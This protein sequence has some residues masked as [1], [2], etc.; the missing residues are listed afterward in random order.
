MRCRFAALL[1]VVAACGASPERARTAKGLIDDGTFAMLKEVTDDCPTPL[2]ARPEHCP[3]DR[4][5]DNVVERV[6]IVTVE[7]DASGTPVRAVDL[8]DRANEACAMSLRYEG[9]GTCTVRLRL[10]R[11]ISDV[12]PSRLLYPTVDCTQWGGPGA[13][14]I[15][16]VGPA[17]Y[18]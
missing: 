5:L 4:P 1:I 17:P 16:T 15:T 9:A 11:H 10:V 2:R 8:D 12:T 3:W 13:A 18:R 6:A 7:T 14:C